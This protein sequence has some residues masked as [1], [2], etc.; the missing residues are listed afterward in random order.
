MHKRNLN[1]ESIRII[2]MLMIVYH[3]FSIHSEWNM[4]E[5]LGLRSYLITVTGSFGKIGVI[6][7]VLITGY[8]FY[9]KQNT[10]S[11]IWKLN[12]LITFYTLTIFFLTLFWQSLEFQKLIVS[13][14]PIIFEQYWFVTGYIILL[15]FQPLLNKY[16]TKTSRKNKLTNLL[17]I[18][19]CFYI[20]S[21]VGTIFQISPFF[22]PSVY[23]VFILIALLGDLIREYQSELKTAFFNY[24]VIIFFISL[25]LILA[26]PLITSFLQNHGVDY[27]FYLID[28]TQSLNA[29][30]FSTSLF[31]IILNF[32]ISNKLEKIIVFLSS[33]TFE[34]YLIHDNRILRPFIWNTLF[35]NSNFY[36]SSYLPLIVILEPLLVFIIC[37]L[38]AKTRQHTINFL[39]NKLISL[40]AR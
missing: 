27:P 2:S 13:L 16:I 9:K 1:I 37:A 26:K 33:T 39:N 23:L 21:F 35:K 29:I 6:L 34:I 17:L 28:G 3:H 20:P 31:V 40:K 15:L 30:L 24:I 8:F 19:S 22:S 4:P 5:Q 32:S 36:W 18:F 10:L 25:G 38:I 12:N 14:F 7:F 11:K